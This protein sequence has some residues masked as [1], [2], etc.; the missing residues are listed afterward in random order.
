MEK[1]GLSDFFEYSETIPL[2]HFAFAEQFD[3]IRA[4]FTNIPYK[5]VM[6]GKL[7]IATSAMFS[8]DVTHKESNK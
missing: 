4:G 1:P 7:P 6:Y 3:T 2:F 8:R 5:K